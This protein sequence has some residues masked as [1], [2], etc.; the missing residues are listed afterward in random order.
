M[1]K[2]IN[3]FRELSMKD[4]EGYEELT[5]SQKNIFDKTYKEHLQSMT[6]KRRLRYTEDHIVSVEGDLKIVKVNFDTDE[7]YI[8][9]QDNKW[10]K[11]S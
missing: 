2:V 10:I 3:L 8:Y 4:V 9:L 1:V 11:I 7:W 5:L 6:R